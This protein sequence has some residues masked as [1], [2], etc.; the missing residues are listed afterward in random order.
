MYFTVY[1][2][3]HLLW[4]FKTVLPL[5]IIFTRALNETWLLKKSTE[6]HIAYSLT[7]Y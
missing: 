7:M 6:E 5:V 2:G 1:K 4:L 3:A